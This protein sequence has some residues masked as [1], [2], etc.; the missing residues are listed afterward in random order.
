MRPAATA[1]TSRGAPPAPARLLV[2]E[3]RRG[4]AVA[5]VGDGA[6]RGTDLLVRARRYAVPTPAARDRGHAGVGR[7]VGAAA[8]TIA[9]RLASLPRPIEPSVGGGPSATR[10]TTFYNVEASEQGARDAETGTAITSVRG[11]ARERRR[12]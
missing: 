3:L 5:A 12:R 11:C 4:A 1:T 6:R 9:T 10:L 2:G 8:T 7:A